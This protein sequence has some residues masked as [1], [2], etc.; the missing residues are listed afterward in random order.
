MTLSPALRAKF[1]NKGASIS[2]IIRCELGIG[3]AAGNGTC[4]R[5]KVERGVERL[6][7]SLARAQMAES[8]AGLW[9]AR[10][11]QGL[12]AFLSAEALDQV[13]SSETTAN[14]TKIAI[15]KSQDV[16][17][18]AETLIALLNAGVSANTRTAGGEPLLYLAA[19]RGQMRLVEVLLERGADL[20][21]VTDLNETPLV[22][23]AGSA[24]AGYEMVKFLLEKGA[25]ATQRVMSGMDV[26]SVAIAGGQG[27]DVIVALSEAGADLLDRRDSGYTPLIEAAARNNAA[28]IRALVKLGVDA[29]STAPGTSQTALS[30]AL[31]SWNFDATVALIECGADVAMLDRVNLEE[32]FRDDQAQ[33]IRSAIAEKLIFLSTSVPTCAENVHNDQNEDNRSRRPTANFS[34]L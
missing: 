9:Y 23:A 30:M 27:E 8:E 13:L 19:K 31:A 20:E 15:R 21:C 3:S 22:G 17:G 10:V 12:K 4:D 33:R 14:V 11:L 6:L 32:G 5:K 34:P 18:S 2:E 24:E 7:W 28:A 1:Q 29:N 26:L 25:D 16:D